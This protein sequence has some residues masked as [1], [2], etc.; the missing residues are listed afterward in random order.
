MI[1]IRL[2]AATLATALLAT[3]LAASEL[4]YRVPEGL[5]YTFSEATRSDNQLT[6]KGNG[7]EGQV[8]QIVATSLAGAATVVAV[9]EGRPSTVRLSFD[10]TSRTEYTINGNVQPEPFALAGQSVEVDVSG[11]RIVAVRQSGSAISVDAAT[12]DAIAPFVVFHQSLL[13]DGRASVGHSWPA[14][15]V[16]QDGS[17]RTTLTVR[18]ADLPTSGPARLMTKGKVV[19]RKDGSSAMGDLTGSM[20][21]DRATGLPELSTGEGAIR[22]SGTLNQSGVTMQLRGEGTIRME[23]SID[24]GATASYD[25][26]AQSAYSDWGSAAPAA[27]P[28]TPGTGDQRLVGIFGGESISSSDY[29]NDDL[30]TNTQLKWVFNANGTVYFGAQAHFNYESRDYNLEQRWGAS[31]HSAADVDS[32]RWSTNG[33]ILTIQWDNGNVSTYAFGF[34]P[35]GALVFRNARTRKLINF[36]NRMR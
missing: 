31:G 32:G 4:A 3:S 10:P 2:T 19:H 25:Q 9:A 7:Q 1:S 11:E 15:V 6:I 17:T 13:P 12:L 14:S 16:S 36:Y 35:N 29:G 23:R 24:I 22:L 21:V 27:A 28:S 34:E 20:R 33:D 5:N 8:Q 26:P 30:Y 18:I